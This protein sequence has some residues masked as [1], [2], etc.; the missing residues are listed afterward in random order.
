MAA[1]QKINEYKFGGKPCVSKMARWC[2]DAQLHSALFSC[3]CSLS[4]VA[5]ARHSNSYFVELNSDLAGQRR[6]PFLLRGPPPPPPPLLHLCYVLVETMPSSLTSWQSTR[7]GGGAPPSGLCIS[8]H[9]CLPSTSAPFCLSLSQ[10]KHVCF[11][12]CST[13]G[14]TV[15]VWTSHV[16]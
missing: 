4:F 13:T 14:L 5:S 11:F 10:T 9:C 12:F 7:W 8:P 15:T 2:V 1:C 3:F 16:D 6:G